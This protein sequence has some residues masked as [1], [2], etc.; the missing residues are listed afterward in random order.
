MNTCR[1]KAVVVVIASTN[2]LRNIHTHTLKQPANIHESVNWAQIE[3]CL[4][5]LKHAATCSIT[6]VQLVLCSW[7]APKSMLDF[8]LKAF[9]L[10]FKLYIAGKAASNDVY[11]AWQFSPK[12]CYAIHALLY[13]CVVSPSAQKLAKKFQQKNSKKNWEEFHKP[14]PP[15]IDGFPIEIDVAVLCVMYYLPMRVSYLVWVGQ[16]KRRESQHTN[17]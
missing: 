8:F 16:R 17:K 5:P 6:K 14:W 2:S 13:L 12:V 10:A 1:G 11:L 15:E 7:A 4:L 9:L 3:W